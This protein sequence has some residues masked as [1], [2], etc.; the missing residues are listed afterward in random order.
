MNNFTTKILTHYGSIARRISTDPKG[1]TNTYRVNDIYITVQYIPEARVYKIG[2]H[3]FDDNSN[4]TGSIMVHN[5]S[6]KGVYNFIV[7]VEDLFNEGIKRTFVSEYGD[8][9][10]Y[11]ESNTLSIEYIKERN[12]KR[13]KK[14]RII[15]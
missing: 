1:N 3:R 15:C 13:S 9:R 11:L 14:R 6:R 4:C 2:A 12:S 10:S 7:Q 8:I 5:L